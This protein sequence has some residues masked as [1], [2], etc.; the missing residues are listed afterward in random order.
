MFILFWEG[1]ISGEQGIGLLKRRG[2]CSN[3]FWR[4]NG[5]KKE[6]VEVVND[7]LGNLWY[8]KEE[9]FPETGHA[10]G[11]LEWL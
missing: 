9:S 2:G 5:K 7:T 1:I 6:V 8:L 3:C 11:P 4:S 10:V